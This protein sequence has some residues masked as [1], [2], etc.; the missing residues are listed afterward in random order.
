VSAGAREG[1]ELWPFFSTCAGSNRSADVTPGML[2]I[3][4]KC[5]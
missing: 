3:N 1:S 4:R 2:C 5:Q